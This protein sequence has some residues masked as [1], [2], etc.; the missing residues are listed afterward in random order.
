M[1]LLVFIL[2]F[3]TFGAYAGTCTSVSRTNASSNTVLTSSKYNTDLNTLYSAHNAYDGGC[4]TSGT[5]EADALL[6]TDFPE[7]GTDAI[8]KGVVDGC[9]ITRK[10]ADEIYVQGCK[11]AI[12]GVFTV[13]TG[14][15]TVAMGCTG[16]TTET[17]STMFYVYV[18]DSSTTTTLD[19]TIRGNQ[20]QFDGTLGGSPNYRVIGRFYN[21]SAGDIDELSITPWIKNQFAHVISDWVSFT[22]TG[23]FTTNSTYTG[24]YRRNGTNLEARQKITFTGASNSAYFSFDLPLTYTIVSENASAPTG[25]KG[26]G[27]GVGGGLVWDNSATTTFAMAAIVQ[28]A[29]Q[30]HFPLVNATGTYIYNDFSNATYQNLDFFLGQ[31][32]VPVEAFGGIGTLY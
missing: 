3:L 26:T 32:S 20:P 14:L 2:A 18:T 25:F 12:N 31:Y 28:D 22:P 17:T 30:V 15:T 13:S 23:D 4:I 10:D 11:I 8:R 19:V 27:V 29:T 6:A 24:Y 7:I 21:D 16:C 5:I 9:K 1:K